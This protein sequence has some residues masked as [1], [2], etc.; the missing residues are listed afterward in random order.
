MC[1]VVPVDRIPHR[2]SYS[3]FFCVKQA[4][5]DGK[6][7]MQKHYNPVV[8]EN[9]VIGFV[10]FLCVINIHNVSA[11]F[12]GMCK[13]KNGCGQLEFQLKPAKSIFARNN[14]FPAINGCVCVYISS[15]FH[16]LCTLGSR[17]VRAQRKQMAKTIYKLLNFQ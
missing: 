1:T 2:I 16:S 9:D 14:F 3:N 8:S 6:N 10:V 13:W 12:G 15:I 4:K 17:C 5:T 11:F 7:E